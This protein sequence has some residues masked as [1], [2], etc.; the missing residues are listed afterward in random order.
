MKAVLITAD[1]F[2]PRALRSLLE[3]LGWELIV[4]PDLAASL[5]LTS[6]NL[7]ACAF[8]HGG[9]IDARLV[10]VV[11]QSR[12]AGFAATFVV[13]GEAAAEWEERAYTSGAS[14][15]FLL[16]LRAPLLLLQLGRLPP[17]P[18][19]PLPAPPPGPAESR[20]HAPNPPELAIIRNIG[21]LL[22]HSNDAESFVSDYIELLRE[23][24]GVNRVA[25]Y[26]TDPAG[27]PR[28]LCAYTAGLDA[29]VSRSVDLSLDAG[30]GA[31]VRVNGLALSVHG[32]VPPEPAARREMDAL[33]ATIV[34]PVRTT[35]QLMGVLLVG[36]RL[37]GEPLAR[38]EV[39]ILFTLMEDLARVLRNARS[40]G[41]LSRERMLFSNVLEQMRIGLLV[42][43]RDLKVVHANRTMAACFGLGDAAALTFHGLPNPLS[44][45]VHTVLQGKAPNAEYDHR[46]DGEPPSVFHI[47]VEPFPGGAGE[48][49]MV[50][51]LAHDHTQFHAQRKDAVAKA[52]LA[53]IGRIGEQFSHIFNNALTPLSA[54][55]QLLPANP[56]SNDLLG[57]MHRVLP[58]AIAR[59]Q[60]HINQVY[61]FSGAEASLPET[62]ELLPL[63]REAWQKANVAIGWDK[64]MSADA[65]GRT[66][67]LS[68]PVLPTALVRVSRSALVTSL[69]EIF[70]NA[71][72]ASP[73]GAEILATFN[74]SQLSRIVVGIHDRG[75]PISDDV[76]SRAGEAFFTTKSSGLG[77]GLC[78]VQKVLH[79]HNG[80]FHIGPSERTNGTACTFSLPVVQ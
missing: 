50:L 42:F 44:S 73:P 59:L 56:A 70:M 41:E 61:F 18:A 17:P 65:P 40:H 16:P 67:R 12:I 48:S 63:I 2:F 34:I 35:D 10:E 54:F 3:P 64:D 52:Q 5:E 47:T 26:V 13:A 69:F 53:I 21:R 74:Q 6:P 62:T 25:L 22:K 38:E 79:E 78:V 32:P 1:G 20:P 9:A 76:V 43:G 15:V 4:A 27:G 51:L 72:E 58:P 23:V 37:L 24:L 71:M 80:T 14:F 77:L 33:G 30:I 75:T 29:R 31:F 39:N 28:L 57:D 49:A 36:P 7:C 11:R 46:L 8:V 55:T 45:L 19:Q 66:F 68:M 60:R